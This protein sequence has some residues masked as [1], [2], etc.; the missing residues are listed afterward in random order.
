MK[1]YFQVAESTWTP[2][3]S[4]YQWKRRKNHYVQQRRHSNLRSSRSL[5]PHSSKRYENLYTSNVLK[6]DYLLTS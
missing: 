1:Y 2:Q 4:I 5:W 6:T 3:E